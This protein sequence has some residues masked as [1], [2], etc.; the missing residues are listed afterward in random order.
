VPLSAVTLRDQVLRLTDA[1]DPD[2]VGFPTTPERTSENWAQAARAFFEELTAFAVIPGTHDL[3]EEAF[4]GA[5]V[6]TISLPGAG[7][8]ALDAA[9]AA[10]AGALASGVAP[11]SGAAVPPPGP[12][13]LATAIPLPVSTPGPPAVAIGA[14]V[15]AW[16]GT[17]SF[18]PTGGSAIPWA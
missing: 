16:A 9:F 3:A 8:A 12:L 10:Y 5:S 13:A 1:T 4:Y 18:T 15:K 17:G 14:H 6:A 7:A 2:F 11:G